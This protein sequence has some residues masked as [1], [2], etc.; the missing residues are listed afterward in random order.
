MRTLRTSIEIFWQNRVGSKL[1]D[2]PV[3]NEG[4]IIYYQRCSRARLSCIDNSI[5]FPINLYNISRCQ[6]ENE[7]VANQI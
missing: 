1:I 7:S 5:T 6:H 2:K 3:G 4:Q